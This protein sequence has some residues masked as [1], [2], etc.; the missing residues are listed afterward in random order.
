MDAVS[1]LTN[2]G[3]SIEKDSGSNFYVYFLINPT[4]K[5]IFYV[6]K[7]KGR[8]VKQHYSNYINGVSTN[9]VKNFEIFEIA[10]KGLRPIEF[11]LED[12]LTE[13]RALRLEK[14]LI[15]KFRKHGLTNISSGNV[16]S[17]DSTQKH[18]EYLIATTMPFERWLAITPRK[19][20]EIDTYHY[21]VRNMLQLRDRLRELNP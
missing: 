4:T 20:Y 17:L 8:R 2:A 10:S 16:S 6:G 3:F 1:S 19:Q 11:V 13:S 5:K 12:D 14:L 15:L 9:G 21:C 18:N 7:G